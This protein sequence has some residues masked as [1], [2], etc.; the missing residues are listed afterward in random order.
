[1]RHPF[2]KSSENGLGQ[3]TNSTA[4]PSLYLINREVNLAQMFM[5]DFLR[6]RLFYNC[7]FK[8]RTYHGTVKR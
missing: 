5:V 8:G 7:P 4:L 1:M 2:T 3:T 6:I